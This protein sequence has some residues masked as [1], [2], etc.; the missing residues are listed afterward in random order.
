MIKFR[1]VTMD[2]THY[3]DTLG[4]ARKIYSEKLSALMT[5]TPDHYIS[6]TIDG[7]IVG[8]C[9][10][11][12]ADTHHPLT[13]ETYFEKDI[14]AQLSNGQPLRRSACAECGGRAVS[15]DVADGMTG[16]LISLGLAAEIVL[17][18]E[19]LDIQYIAMTTN[20]GIRLIARELDCPLV[21][22]G[23]PD[24]SKKTAEF[25]AN[26][27]TFFNIRQHCYGFLVGNAAAGSRRVLKEIAA[28]RATSEA[29]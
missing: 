21:S 9:G 20:R 24:L 4:F 12:R 13:I 8:C 1:N 26:W 6:A 25:R 3:A 7:M 14:F 15:T 10:L 18:A 2:D 5:G 23:E 28:Y 29:V 27:E 19:S 16:Q 22:F 17:L 11:Y